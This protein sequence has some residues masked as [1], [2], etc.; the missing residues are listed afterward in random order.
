MLGETLADI[1]VTDPR[2]VAWRARRRARERAL[3]RE[4][5][6]HLGSGELGRARML[7]AAIVTLPVRPE[8][9]VDVARFARRS[10]DRA[11]REVEKKR[12]CP[13]TD[14]VGLHELRIA[15]KNLRYTSEIF[16]QA[17]PHDLAAMEKPAA[18]FQKRL[19]EIH[20]A[21][22]ALLTVGRA[23]GLPP[24]VRSRVLK[25]ISRGRAERVRRYLMEMAPVVDA[26]ASVPAPRAVV[27]TP[28]V[29]LD[30]GRSPPSG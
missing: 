2:F 14:A 28:A 27:A 4:V 15:Y 13:T 1:P 24:R 7:L 6:A 3:R 29:A 22:M 8:R 23:R 16:A 5:Q 9:D 10:I 21:D 17:L 11:R 18:Q 30:S 26:P 19:G 20:D 12:D 25:E